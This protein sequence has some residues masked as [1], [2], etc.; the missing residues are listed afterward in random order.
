MNEVELG[1]FL[2][3]LSLIFGLTYILGSFL[4]QLKIP[5]ILAALFI[6]V[7]LSYTPFLSFVDAGTNF[8]N[9]FEFLSNLGVL[10]LLFYIGLQIDLS[11]MKKSSSDIVW[12]TV[13]NTILPF[14]FGT[15]A[16]LLFGYGWAIALVIGMTRMPTAEAVIVPILDEFKMIKTRIGTFIIGAGVLDDIIE[17]LLVGI[18][19]IWVSTKTVQHHEGITAL[20]LGI[21]VFMLVAWI[22]YMWMHKVMQYYKPKSLNTLMIF[23]LVILFGFG[24]FAE[25][26]ELGMVVGA[27]AAG[28]IMRPMY[29]SDEKQG[30]Q[31]T[32]MTQTLSYGFFGILFFFWIGF[33]ADIQGFIK[34]PLLAIVLYLVGTLGK[35]FG[36]LLMVPMKKITLKEA[37]I[38]G[39]GLDARL[40]TEII[41]AQLLFS[42]S[43]IDIKLFTALVAASSFTAITVPL[44]FSLLIRLWPKEARHES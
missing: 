6:G 9:T 7:F 24:G 10:F 22:F 27:I 44:L 33:N 16:M 11:E 41:V 38:V 14:I 25:Y 36:V 21:V 32:K 34:E 35:L 39:V 26:V 15:A 20:A 1:K 13:L 29:E 23:S 8:K 4:S 42:A 19:S 31:L 37:V 12:L 2:L 40:T 30:E 17:V 5:T 3:S 28:V 43:I 18:V